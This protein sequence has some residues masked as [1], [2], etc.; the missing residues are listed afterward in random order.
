MRTIILLTVY[1]TISVLGV[2]VLLY[3]YWTKNIRP[4]VFVVKNSIRLGLKILGIRM[5]VLGN[6]RID[7][8]KPYIFMPNHLS[9]LDA[10]MVFSLIRQKTSVISKK[11]IFRIPFVGQAM[12]T[13]GFVEVDRK[14]AGGGRIAVEHAAKLIEKAGFSFLVFPEGTRSHNGELQAFRRGGF[15]LAI[16]TGLPIVPVSINGTFELMPKKK[17]FIKSGMVR[18]I[19][20]DP[21]SVSGY[22]Q[23]SLPEL[24]DKVCHSIQS[25]L[26]ELKV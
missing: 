13:A 24:M 21:V 20:H 22:D 10:P 5:K 7:K 12:K 26:K 17:I 23:D 9:N 18:I 3:S 19:F 4:L 25:G 6:D 2:P 11:D 14:G 15:F 16:Q 1:I 8:Q